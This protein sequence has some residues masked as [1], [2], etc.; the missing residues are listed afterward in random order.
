MVFRFVYKSAWGFV[1]VLLKSRN[2]AN[3]CTYSTAELL[4]FISNIP[5]VILVF[6]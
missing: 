4:E 1:W 2:D 3:Y 6:F 5:S